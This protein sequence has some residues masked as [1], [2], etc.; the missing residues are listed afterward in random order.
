MIPQDFQYSIINRI[1]F[2]QY[3]KKYLN[4]IISKDYVMF[5]SGNKTHDPDFKFDVGGQ[6]YNYG[7]AAS[8]KGK[9]MYFGDYH[10]RRRV[11][12]LKYVLKNSEKFYLGISNRKLSNENNWRFAF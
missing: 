7:C 2:I 6:K 12:L 8:F 10:Y 3:L 9:M 5:H 1:I 11:S 4:Y